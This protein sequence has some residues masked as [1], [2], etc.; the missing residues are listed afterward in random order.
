MSAF[1]DDLKSMF[2]AAPEPAAD[3]DFT[4]IVSTRIAKR[5]RARA[6][7]AQASYAACGLALA[8]VLNV[9]WLTLHRLLPPALLKPA[10]LTAAITAPVHAPS[11]PGLL[12][13]L[14]L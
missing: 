7:A 14:P 5:E 3:R 13:I 11:A 6:F 2:A 1:E 4:D 8:G 12:Q 10:T 9:L